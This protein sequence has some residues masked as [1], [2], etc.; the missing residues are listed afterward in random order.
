MDFL[1]RKIHGPGVFLHILTLG[2]FEHKFLFLWL[3]VLLLVILLRVYHLGMTGGDGGGL[4]IRG[5]LSVLECWG[6]FSDV[7]FF[8]WGPFLWG[9]EGH[10][11]FCPCATN[12]SIMA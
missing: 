3:L 2:G 11:F 9:L 5:G 12:S 4:G 7:F 10:I 6:T 8:I 1:I